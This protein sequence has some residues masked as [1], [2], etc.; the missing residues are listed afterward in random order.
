MSASNVPE[1]A[2]KMYFQTFC[3][4]VCKPV[5]DLMAKKEKIKSFEV[6]FKCVYLYTFSLGFRPAHTG[7]C[8]LFA[9]DL[10]GGSWFVCRVSG[11]T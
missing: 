6:Y 8:C 4:M 7:V 5:V 9:T 1:T 2:V 3:V 11:I 10:F